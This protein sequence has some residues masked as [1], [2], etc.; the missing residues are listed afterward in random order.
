MT[1]F[2]QGTE[3]RKEADAA[4]GREDRK[5]QVRLERILANCPEAW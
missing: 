4:G 3:N 2:I 1:W 5:I